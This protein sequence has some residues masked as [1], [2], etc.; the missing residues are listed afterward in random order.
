MKPPGRLVVVDGHELHVTVDRPADGAGSSGPAVL[1]IGGLGGNWFDWDG[2]AREL[3]R[4][5]TVVRFDRPG[6]GFGAASDIPPT[7]RGEADRAAAVLRSVSVAGP[8]TVV[9]HSLG[10]FYAEAFA[11]LMPDLTA[12]LILLDASVSAGP[13]GRLPREWRV[14]AARRAAAAISASGAQR[15]LGAG[16]ARM[17]NRAALPPGTHDRMRRISRDPRY[18]GAV[19]VEEAVYP[20]LVAEVAALRES[21]P[22]LPVPRAVVA[23]HTGR[24]TPWGALRLR[25]QRG[26]AATLD[27]R[28]VVLRPAHHYAMIDQP[29][30]LSAVVLSLV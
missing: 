24:R 3:A 18:L 10:G 5:R 6:F 1:L 26:L 29:A 2:V 27:A 23:A 28:F 13:R 30:R 15:A 9:G 11:R 4:E 21:H 25:T 8:V 14:A 22:L 19:L 20:D 17:L 7:A 12:G 16:V